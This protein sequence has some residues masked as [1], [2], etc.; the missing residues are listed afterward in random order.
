MNEET[1][2]LYEDV[3]GVI[4]AG[5]KSKRMGY[6]KP[7]LMVEGKTMFDSIL[8][9]MRAFFKRVIISGNRPDLA[10]TNIP[11]YKDIYPG[12]ALGGLFTALKHSK[13][14]FIFCSSS[15]I[16]FPDE[17]IVRLLL[18]KR[19]GYDVVVPKTH[20]GFEPLFAI[21][22]KNCLDNMQQMLE[23]NEFRIYDFYPAVNVRYVTIDELPQGWKRSLMNINTPKELEQIKEII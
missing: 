5:G 2:Y 6:D 13:T 14:P 8:D 22:N 7:L 1:E 17:R 15:D 16:P 4:L 12:S 11:F 23:K 19:K 18:S 21:Y 3:T 9:V 10:D 20:D